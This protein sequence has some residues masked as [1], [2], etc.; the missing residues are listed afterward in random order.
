M[1]FRAV[2][3]IP[4][5]IPKPIRCWLQQLQ[6]LQSQKNYNVSRPPPNQLCQCNLV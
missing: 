3:A 2:T 5:N 4:F 1:K 6:K